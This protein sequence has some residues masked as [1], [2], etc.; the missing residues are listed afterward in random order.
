MLRQI[1]LWILAILITATA[2][3]YQRLTGPTYP[4]TS[5]AEIAGQTIGYSLKRNPYVD[6]D[7]KVFIVIPDSTIR[8][9]IFYRRYKVSEPFTQVD[10]AVSGDSLIGYL[11]RQP[12]AG[13][14]E[15]Y[16][17]LTHADQT[18]IIPDERTVVSR[19][20]GYV[21]TSILVPHILMM[22]LGMIWATRT[23][24]EA[25]SPTGNTKSLTLCTTLMLFLGGLIFGPIVQKI[26][27][28]D[29]W[30]GVPFGW[31]LT[32]NKTLI[33][34]VVW[35]LALLRH[36]FNPSPR[37][38]VLAAAIITLAMYL[39]PHSALGSEFDYTTGE[40]KTG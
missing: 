10:M 8:G 32:D 27:F 12:A 30:T 31:D 21:P 20:K 23:G 40:V 34:V 1:I 28:G 35:G 39:I 2:F 33:F 17:E 6:E 7:L 24:L 15:Y 14:L 9:T 37:Y 36:K 3:I 16:A 38:F 13:K 5:S 22:V 19:F 4:V 18:V 29:L 25:I 11:P 26:A